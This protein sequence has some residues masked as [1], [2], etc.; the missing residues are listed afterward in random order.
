MVTIEFK[1]KKDD[2][3]IWDILSTKAKHGFRAIPG[4][5]IINERDSG[6]ILEEISKAGIKVKTNAPEQTKITARFNASGM[7]FF[8][9]P[10]TKQKKREYDER[11][12]NRPITTKTMDFLGDSLFFPN[13][14]PD[15]KGL[16]NSCQEK[17][18]KKHTIYL[19]D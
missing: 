4:A 15:F 6:E 17:M 14:E 7:P 5:H 10:H 2:R 12:K 13:P 1:T 19:L 8:N 3:K 18:S 9:C 16:C 11:M